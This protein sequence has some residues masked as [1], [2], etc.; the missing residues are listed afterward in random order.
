MKIS[1][2]V[3]GDRVLFKLND[4]NIV[5]GVISSINLPEIVISQEQI[6]FVEA[7]TI[8]KSQLVSLLAPFTS[9]AEVPID[10]E[11]DNEEII[12]IPQHEEGK[13]SEA[14]SLNISKLLT[15]PGKY[16][17]TKVE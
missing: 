17:I 12:E 2:L 4:S 6:G 10:H 5:S 16:K 15:R 13:I 11:N 1:K 9:Y 3:V 7:F 8:D 14:N